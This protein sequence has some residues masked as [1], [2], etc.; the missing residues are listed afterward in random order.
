MFNL[1][2]KAEKE[3]IRREYRIRLTIVALWFSFATLLIASILLLPSLLLSTAKEKAAIGRFTA[4]STIVER[5]NTAKLE[6]VLADTQSRLSLFRR[7]VP[8]LYLHELLMRLA[9]YRSDKVSFTNISFTERQSGQGAGP[10]DNAGGNREVTIAGIARDR[11][12]LLA[13][14]QSLER[15]GLFA[16]VEVP[17]SN[18]AKGSNISFSL[19]VTGR[20]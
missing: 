14:V 20:F 1:L 7:T 19:R 4:L 3:T 2:P 6:K 5:E 13:L 15:S 12:G 8:A 9:S 17:V 16:R 10:A 11:A 18:Y